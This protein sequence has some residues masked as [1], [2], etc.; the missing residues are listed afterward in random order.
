MI[1]PLFIKLDKAYS[2]ID[3]LKAELDRLTNTIFEAKAFVTCNCIIASS[4][5]CKLQAPLL[6]ILEGS[7]KQSVLNTTEGKA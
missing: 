5:S 7:D 3:K 1:D 4:I 6:E 2:E